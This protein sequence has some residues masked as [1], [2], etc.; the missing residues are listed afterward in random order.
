MLSDDTEQ[1]W[2]LFNSFSSGYLFSLFLNLHSNDFHCLCK[3]A[4][5]ISSLTMPLFDGAGSCVRRD[6][7][8]CSCL[9]A[10]HVMIRP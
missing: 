3:T 4:P 10:I 8:P 9:Q 6:N 1:M 5:F 2:F 7:D